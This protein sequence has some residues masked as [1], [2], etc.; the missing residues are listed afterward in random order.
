MKKL[1]LLAVVML[2]GCSPRLSY[3]TFNDKGKP[4]TVTYDGGLNNKE[5]SKIEAG[6]D[7]KTGELMIFVEGYKTEQQLISELI[8]MLAAYQTGVV[9]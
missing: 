1:L 7:P 4:T 5:V 3:Q 8:K 9:Q 6:I 2:A